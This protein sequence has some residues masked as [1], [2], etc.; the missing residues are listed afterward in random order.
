MLFVPASSGV[1]SVNSKLLSQVTHFA[2]AS[3]L[4]SCT[5]MLAWF[6][7]VLFSLFSVLAQNFLICVKCQG[8]IVSIESGLW[9][10]LSMVVN[11]AGTSD[12]FLI[13]NMRSVCG[14]HLL[15]IH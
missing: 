15:P 3:N 7:E 4:K 9:N 11:L 14:A 1:T 2:Q 13:Q 10:V 12:F 8:C 6:C 5:S